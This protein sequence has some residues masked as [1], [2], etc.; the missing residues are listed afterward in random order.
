MVWNALGD[1]HKQFQTRS[2]GVQQ[3]QYQENRVL[4]ALHLDT[5]ASVW[6]GRTANRRR[7]KRIKKDE[8]PETGR[9]GANEAYYQ[10]QSL[11]LEEWPLPEL[12][13]RLHDVHSKP[14]RGLEFEP[15]SEGKSQHDTTIY[16]LHLYSLNGKR[17]LAYEDQ[18]VGFGLCCAG[19]RLM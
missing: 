3:S 16:C 18:I 14:Q 9:S 15:C 17:F 19:A 1:P 7:N 10:C 13:P 4:T 6:R 11:S 12:R 8:W 2:T 5:V